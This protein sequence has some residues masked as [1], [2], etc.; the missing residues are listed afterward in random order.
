MYLQPDTY[1]EGTQT[2]PQNES[3]E[4][5]QKPSM[6]SLPTLEITKS[7]FISIIQGIQF[8]KFSIPQ[9]A[10]NLATD[11]KSDFLPF[12]MALLEGFKDL[13]LD[14]SPRQ[15]SPK[16]IL[17]QIP[18]DLIDSPSLS[19][20]KVTAC[21]LFENVAQGI[22]HSSIQHDNGNSFILT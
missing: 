14:I 1:R 13:L 2:P 11:D 17:Q 22:H 16:Q 19:D 9:S 4:T 8:E 20:S 5:P 18:Y 6:H 21:K 10:A 7:I 3:F 15:T 12:V